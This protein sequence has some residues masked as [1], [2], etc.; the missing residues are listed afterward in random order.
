M[1]GHLVKNLQFEGN[2][3]TTVTNNLISGAY[4]ASAVINTEKVNK[5]IIVQ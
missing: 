5:R 2:S 4:V 3:I 1:S